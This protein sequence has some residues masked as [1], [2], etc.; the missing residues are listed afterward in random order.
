[1]ARRTPRRVRPPAPVWHQIVVAVAGILQGDGY[2]KRLGERDAGLDNAR[3]R[4]PPKAACGVGDRNL[5]AERRGK[6]Q[7]PRQI[8]GGF[9]R[10][11]VHVGGNRKAVQAVRAQPAS[12]VGGRGLAEVR[13]VEIHIALDERRVTW[14][15]WA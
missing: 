11:L 5:G 1:M 13:L 10:A 3:E 7:A 2:A 15:R 6:P 4:V 12:H 14:M 8:L 9:G